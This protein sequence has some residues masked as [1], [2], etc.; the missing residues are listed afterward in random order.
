MMNAEV[1]A[2]NRPACDLSQHMCTWTSPTT[3]KYQCCVQI[4]VIFLHELP[5]VFIGFLSVMFVEQGAKIF[6]ARW[7]ILSLALWGPSTADRYQDVEQGLPECRPF[8]LV[9]IRIPPRFFAESPAAFE[10]QEH[11]MLN[12]S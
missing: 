6:L 8:I 12:E 10:G 9:P 5:V 3:Y 4:L 1:T 11:I 2:E 7:Q